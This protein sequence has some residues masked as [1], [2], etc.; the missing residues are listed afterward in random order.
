MS[1]KAS[2]EQLR[3]CLRQVHQALVVLGLG[4]L[5]QLD[6]G[7]F[8]RDDQLRDLWSIQLIQSYSRFDLSLRVFA[9]MLLL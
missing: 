1:L 7:G 5:I 9:M 2:C 6:V 3:F 4:L 8:T